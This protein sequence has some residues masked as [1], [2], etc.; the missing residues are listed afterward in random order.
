MRHVLL[1]VAIALI[2]LASPAWSR[3][4]TPPDIL[5]SRQLAARQHIRAGDVVE[6]AIDATGTGARQF[7]VAGTY[8]PMPDPMRFAQERLEAR[9]HL[10]DML[11]LVAA[12]RP[13]AAPAVNFINVKLADQAAAPSFA[14][15]LERRLPGVI[16]RATSAPDERASTFAVLERFHLAIA[17]V[18]VIGSGVFL[19]ALMVMLVDERRDTVATLRLI[20]LTR[21]RL[22]TQVLVEGGLIAIAG[23]LFGIAFAGVME[24]FF[25]RFFQWRYDTSLV[26]L[27]VTPAIVVRSIALAVPVGVVASAAAAWNFLRHESLHQVGR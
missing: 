13:G 14:R 17:I 21:A 10:P 25:N 6:L 11:P 24:P 12:M 1:A 27:H 7:R 15:D 22:L 23:A 26:F 16:A 5:I 2:A 8:E 19:L 3:L 18:T 9:L 20:G 4:D